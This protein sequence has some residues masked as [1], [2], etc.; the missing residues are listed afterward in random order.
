MNGIDPGKK[1]N[2][3]LIDSKY[4]MILSA[5][6]LLL[7]KFRSIHYYQDINYLIGIISDKRAYNSI[8]QIDD[9]CSCWTG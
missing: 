8:P 4:N 5:N 3:K 2:L 6:L 9:I 1:G 7:D